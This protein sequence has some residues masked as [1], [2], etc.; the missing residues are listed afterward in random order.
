M[1]RIAAFAC[2]SSLAIG[3][4][5]LTQTEEQIGARLT[6]TVHACETLPNH[7]GTLNQAICDRDEAARQD[8]RLNVTWIRAL[9]RVPPARQQALRPSERQW[10]KIRSEE[11]QNDA[12]DYVNLTANYKWREQRELSVYFR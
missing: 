9:R 3:A 2:V 5:A 10:I 11:C 4:R 8:K 7:G 12:A 1:A 6:P